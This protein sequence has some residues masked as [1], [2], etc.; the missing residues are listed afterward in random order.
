MVACMH[1]TVCLCVHENKST[2]QFLIFFRAVCSASS[3]I[4]MQHIL[5]DFASI[6]KPKFFFSHTKFQL[7]TIT[8][9]FYCLQTR[10]EIKQIIRMVFI[11]NYD[12]FV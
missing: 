1:C 4:N 6:Q 7:M 3:T 11:F 12:T 5:S 2:I 10:E 8:N 9:A